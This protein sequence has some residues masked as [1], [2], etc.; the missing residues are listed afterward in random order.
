MHQLRLG[1]LAVRRRERAPGHD[2]R[3][4]TDELTEI[5]VTKDL[6]EMGS[7]SRQEKGRL[8]PHVEAP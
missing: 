5:A 7:G 4:S 2:T 8:D 3:V 6:F 1:V